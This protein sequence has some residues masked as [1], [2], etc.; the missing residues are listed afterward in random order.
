MYTPPSSRAAAALLLG[1]CLCAG[2]PTQAQVLGQ[3]ALVPQ[4]V[5][6]Y[7][8]P[9]VPRVSPAD[10][11]PRDFASA[12]TELRTGTDVL[13]LSTAT[14]TQ[15]PDSLLVVGVAR[16]YV[17]TDL[18]VAIDYDFA[19]ATPAPA[20]G[21]DGYRYD[22]VTTGA[23]GTFPA[24]TSGTRAFEDGRLTSVRNVIG[25]NVVTVAYRYDGE[26]LASW[27]ILDAQGRPTS[28]STVFAYLDDGRLRSYTVYEAEGQRGETYAYDGD[29]LLSATSTGPAA[30]DDYTITYRYNTGVAVGASV[31]GPARA[32]TLTR[33][34][35]G[36]DADVVIIEEAV[37]G[38]GVYRTRYNLRAGSTGLRESAVAPVT[39]RGANPLRPGATLLLEADAALAP[40]SELYDEAGRL[41]SRYPAGARSLALPRLPAGAYVLVVR[42]AGYAPL[43]HRVIVQ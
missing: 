30:T 31:I 14:A 34:D 21:S 37:A 5:G 3:D 15:T 6:A 35:D 29:R 17:G 25:G 18:I 12:R 10:F 22:F 1:A 9:P 2:T 26:R 13:E 20:D 23:G 40:A 19:G 24:T 39:V 27:R 33:V 8:A 42:A 7:L 28:D 32:S 41:V 38:G 11:P 4:L 16:G 36:T 43:R